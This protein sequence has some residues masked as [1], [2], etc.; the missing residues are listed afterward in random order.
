MYVPLNAITYGWEQT[1]RGRRFVV[2]MPKRTSV[3]DRLAVIDWLDKFAGEIRTQYPF[4]IVDF[5]RFSNGYALEI[6]PTSSVE[7]FV[8]Q[9]LR[10]FG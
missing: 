9:S 4:W 7:D 10:N 6:V 1:A 5:Q 3:S 2:R 8:E